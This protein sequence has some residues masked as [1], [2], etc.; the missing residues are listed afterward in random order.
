MR[1]EAHGQSAVSMTF[2]H[3]EILG[4]TESRRLSASLDVGAPQ[5][6][7]ARGRVSWLVSQLGDAP[8]RIVIEAFARNARVASMATLDHSRE[9][10]FAPLDDDK[11]DSH[12][13]RLVQRAEM[14]MGRST[15]QRT[16]G[17]ITTVL[18]VINEFYGDVVQGPGR[19]PPPSSPSPQ[20]PPPPRTSA[21]RSVMTPRCSHGWCWSAPKRSRADPLAMKRPDAG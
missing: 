5:D 14:G 15:G 8:G 7:G 4:A 9:D 16:P 10:R 3:F 2:T 12:R 18:G 1:A 13:F 11:K 17:F 6:R 20:F 21:R 19:P